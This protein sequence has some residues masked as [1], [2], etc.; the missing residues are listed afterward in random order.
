M[1]IEMRDPAAAAK[2]RQRGMSV[3]ERLAEEDRIVAEKEEVRRSRAKARRSKSAPP[4]GAGRDKNGGEEARGRGRQR[5]N[6]AGRRQSD[7]GALQLQRRSRSLMSKKNYR[8]SALVNAVAPAGG[9][10]MSACPKRTDAQFEQGT[11]AGTAAHA[12]AV[13]EWIKANLS[14]AGSELRTIDQR[15]RNVMLFNDWLGQNG[16]EQFADWVKDADGWK[17]VCRMDEELQPQVPTA[18]IMIEY[19][20]Q[21][22]NGDKES[23]PKEG[24]AEHRNGEWYKNE[25]TG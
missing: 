14:D 9:A 6:E 8:R 24:R 4:S 22:A 7:A 15:D 3:L 11:A 10:V 1:S 13:R 5:I 16:Y 2:A 19:A 17:A 25:D 23:C 21:M 18:E 20:F 12:A